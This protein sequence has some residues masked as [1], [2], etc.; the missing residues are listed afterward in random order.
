MCII[1][2]FWSRAGN[3]SD[4]V[5]LLNTCLQKVRFIKH[6]LLDGGINET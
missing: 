4:K 2:I 6:L 1:H 3:P 5:T